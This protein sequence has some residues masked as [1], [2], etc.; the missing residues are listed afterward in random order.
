MGHAAEFQH[1]LRGTFAFTRGALVVTVRPRVKEVRASE[2]GM[3]AS[4]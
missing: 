1:G 2:A 4:H 3:F